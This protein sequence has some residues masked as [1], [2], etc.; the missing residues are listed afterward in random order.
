MRNMI[1]ADAIMSGIESKLSRLLL[2]A[3]SPY[4]DA[5]RF[6]F[7]FVMSTEKKRIS[8]DNKIKLL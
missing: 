2:Q 6:A 7:A 8:L 1:R 3:H 5:R 4:D